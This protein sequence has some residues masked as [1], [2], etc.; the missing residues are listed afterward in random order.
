MA[1]APKRHTRQE[2]GVTVLEAMSLALPTGTVTWE[3][4]FGRYAVTE[5]Q[6]AVADELMSIANAVREI[7]EPQYGA[8]RARQDQEMNLAMIESA[9][10]DRRTLYFPI[11]TLT[12]TERGMHE[13]FREQYGRDVTDLD[14]LVDVFF[15]RR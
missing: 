10:L 3:N 8:A 9:R 12:E 5:G 15:P 13:R 6:V 14:G 1:I 7:R 2:D 11:T 4:P